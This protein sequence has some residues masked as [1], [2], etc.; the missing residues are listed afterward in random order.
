MTHPKLNS[1]VINTN[2]GEAGDISKTSKII[3]RMI[4][5]IKEKRS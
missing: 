2:D 4:N 5:E 1:T 3:T